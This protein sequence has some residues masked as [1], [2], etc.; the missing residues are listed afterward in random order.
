MEVVKCLIQQDIKEHGNTKRN[1]IAIQI[2]NWNRRTNELYYALQMHQWVSE[3][4][5]VF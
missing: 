5:I 2:S 4:E 3:V 1:I